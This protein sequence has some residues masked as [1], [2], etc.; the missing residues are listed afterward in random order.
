MIL[1]LILAFDKYWYWYWYWNPYKYWYWS[2]SWSRFFGR[3]TIDIDIGIEKKI[4]KNID[5]DIE[6]KFH[7]VPPLVQIMD[8]YIQGT[9]IRML[10]MTYI[11]TFYK[12]SR[13][14]RR[15]KRFRYCWPK[16]CN[17]LSLLHC[18]VNWCFCN[19]LVILGFSISFAEITT[20]TF[21]GR[22]FRKNLINTDFRIE[23]TSSNKIKIQCYLDIRNNR[24]CT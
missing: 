3:D 18:D 13:W 11:P 17:H 5:I 2:W 19:K 9:R 14:K 4:L 1:I 15:K 12:S 7:I 21:E 8:P 20:P 6:Q 10:L 16:K 22:G 24:L 23:A